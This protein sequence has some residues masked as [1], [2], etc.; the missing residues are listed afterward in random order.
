MPENFSVFCITTPP[1][2][3]D[4]NNQMV[5]QCFSSSKEV[6][7]STLQFNSQ[8]NLLIDLPKNL[9]LRNSYNKDEVSSKYASKIIVFGRNT[10][11]VSDFCTVC[12]LTTC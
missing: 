7:T 11:N 12:L 9:V 3:I 10:Y 1:E 8:L 6:D 2:M 4:L 5:P